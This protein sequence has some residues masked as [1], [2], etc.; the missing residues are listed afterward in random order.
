MNSRYK[1]AAVIGI[2]ALGFTMSSCHRDEMLMKR[3]EGNW[4][5][6]SSVVTYHYAD[7]TEQE[8]ENLSN[9]GRL[10]ITEGPSD[11]EKNYDFF[12]INTHLDTIQAK[13]ILVTDESRNRMVMMNALVDTTSKKPI[14]WTITKQKRNKQVWSTYGVD[15]TLFY[16]ANN[17]NPGAATNWVSWEIT[18]KRD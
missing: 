5:I 9:T 18:L 8:V 1:K 2:L 7:G 4:N 11:L 6:E 15:S 10:V 12:Y 16:P 14:T 13:D 3:M 17:L